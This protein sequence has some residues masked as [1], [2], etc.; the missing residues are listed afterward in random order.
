MAEQQGRD[1][2]CRATEAEK[3]R[4]QKDHARFD[5]D[6]GDGKAQHNPR[7]RCDDVQI[8]QHPHGKEEQTQQD[9]AE[10]V[11]VSLQLM[12]VRRLGEHDTRHESTQGGG[13]ADHLHD[14]GACTNRK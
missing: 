7:L 4:Q 3:P 14:G 6:Q 12:P 10:R 2:G 9:R 11:N 13:N 8:E 1:D 5:E